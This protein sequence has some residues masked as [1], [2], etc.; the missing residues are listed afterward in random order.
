MANVKNGKLVSSSFI[1]SEFGE[2]IILEP[3]RTANDQGG[4]TCVS[5]CSCACVDNLPIHPTKCTGSGC[6]SSNKIKIYK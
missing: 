2:G 1:G 3:T 5:A 6:G 4:G